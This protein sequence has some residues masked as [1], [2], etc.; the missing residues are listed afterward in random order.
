MA[1]PAR[2]AVGLFG[3]LSL[4]CNVRIWL[5]LI[6]E[7]FFR[8]SPTGDATR[9][10]AHLTQIILSYPAFF[11]SQS[12]VL[13]LMWEEKQTWTITLST[14]KL[15]Q[16]ADLFVFSISFYRILA[17][18]Q[19]RGKILEKILSLDLV[20]LMN[21]WEILSKSL[22]VATQGFNWTLVKNRGL[23]ILRLMNSGIVP[24][25]KPLCCLKRWTDKI[26]RCSETCWGAM[27]ELDVV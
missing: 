21:L 6:L 5:C 13:V 14:S 20:L 4:K 16:V 17:H 15:L 24:V 18:L 12:Q 22:L 8:H 26:L 7:L 9:S 23:H 25:W 3:G 19:R 1:L 27:E 2:E 11:H 10:M